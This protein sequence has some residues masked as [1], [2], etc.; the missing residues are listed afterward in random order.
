MKTFCYWSIPLLLATSS[1]KAQGFDIGLTYAQ[2][3]VIIQGHESNGPG[4]QAALDF[5]EIGRTQFQVCG[6]FEQIAVESTKTVMGNLGFQC[7]V[8]SQGHEGHAL[9]ALEARSEHFSDPNETSTF[10]RLWLRG[11]IGFRGVIIP[12]LPFNTAFLARGT[13]RVVPFTRIEYAVPLWKRELVGLTPPT[14]EVRLQV[15]LRLNLD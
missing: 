8:W 5:G 4:I 2:T 9:L 6:G 1:S 10:G 15:G 13:E 7:T 14:W 12:L 11:G 3:Q